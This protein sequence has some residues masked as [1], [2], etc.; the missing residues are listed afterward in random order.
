MELTKNTLL[1]EIKRLY[2]KTCEDSRVDVNDIIYEDLD[3]RIPMGVMASLGVAMSLDEL[4]WDIDE[5]PH[6]YTCHTLEIIYKYFL[7][8]EKHFNRRVGMDKMYTEEQLKEI[9]RLACNTMFNMGYT[10]GEDM[11]DIED[12]AYYEEWDGYTFNDSEQ[13]IAELIEE[14]KKQL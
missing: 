10:C 13:L 8:I 14:A 4:V 1:N 7:D 2:M 5:R 12:L 6:M 9:V 11:V 3:G